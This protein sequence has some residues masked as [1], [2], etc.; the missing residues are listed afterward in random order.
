MM[1]FM[2]SRSL[3]FPYFVF[4]LEKSRSRFSIEAGLVHLAILMSS[5]WLKFKMVKVGML[6]S[7]FQTKLKMLLL[8]FFY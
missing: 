1:N 8:I 4:L 5:S 3:T 2:N 7:I 6:E